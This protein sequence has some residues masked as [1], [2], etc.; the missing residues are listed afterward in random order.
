MIG[1]GAPDCIGS[2]GA[3]LE[4]V[5]TDT[6]GD[7]SPGGSGALATFGAVEVGAISAISGIGATTAIS[8][9]DPT[10]STR[11]ATPRR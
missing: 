11:A 9:T 2:V 4:A 8:A 10:A 1:A 7:A 5:G 6:D 3:D